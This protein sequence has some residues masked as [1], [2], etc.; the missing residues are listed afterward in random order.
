MNERFAGSLA[1]RT[2]DEFNRDG[3]EAVPPDA[4]VYATVALAEAASDAHDALF[5]AC[6]SQLEQL[7]RA[8]PDSEC[9]EGS[10]T[11]TLENAPAGPVVGQ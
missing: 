9:G 2:S 6:G 1:E 5:D 10:T 7:M 4:G 11:A 8:I 3:D